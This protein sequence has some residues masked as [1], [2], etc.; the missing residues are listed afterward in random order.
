M[1]VTMGC[2]HTCPSS[3][4]S[5]TSTGSWTAPAGQGVE[6]ACPI[7]DQIKTMVVDLITG[8]ALAKPEATA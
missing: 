5:V 8:I 7:R 6:A 4:A 1:C 2:G 3:P